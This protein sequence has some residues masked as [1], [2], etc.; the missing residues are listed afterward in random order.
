MKRLGITG[1]TGAGKTTA[2]NALRQLGAEVVDADAVYHRLLA[3]SEELK[4][5]LVKAFGEEILDNGG[6]IDRKRLSAVVYPHRL[7]E[8]NG[9]THPAIVAEIGKLGT[10]AEKRGC[11]ALAVDA[12]AL[13]ESGLADGC[14]A[15]VSVL[16]PVELRVRRVMARDNI[17]EAYA[18]R[19]VLAQKSDDF[20]RAH[21][22]YVLENS[23]EDT[24][25]VFAER[26]LALFREILGA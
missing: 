24:P 10:L 25:E 4:N 3:E 1:P 5:S 18:R 22:D 7:E 15:V 6:K 23:E 2:L 12:I 20:F 26:A 19:R 17:D 21:S 16:A 14:D 8:L 9:L 11:P 13:V